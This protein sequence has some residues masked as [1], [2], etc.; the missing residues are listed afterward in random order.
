MSFLQ[1][2]LCVCNVLV[3]QLNPPKVK[4]LVP[5][6]GIVPI[7]VSVLPR[8]ELNMGRSLSNHEKVGD[9]CLPI[10]DFCTCSNPPSTRF[11]Q[12]ITSRLDTY[13]PDHYFSIKYKSKFNYH[14]CFTYRILGL[15][16]K[17]MSILVVGCQLTKFVI[18]NKKKPRSH[19][20]TLG[21]TMVET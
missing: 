1:Q 5:P 21:L 19:Y 13:Y 14:M 12:Q 11:N 4:F 2:F 8:V 17:S 10:I 9:S 18:L 7:F 6:L 20:I 3:L 15:V 16:F